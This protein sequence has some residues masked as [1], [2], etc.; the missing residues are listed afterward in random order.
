MKKILFTFVLAMVASLGYSQLSATRELDS[1]FTTY[2]KNGLFFANVLLKRDGKTLYQGTSGYQDLAAGIKNNSQTQMLI[3]SITKTYTAVV[4]LQLVEEGMLQLDDKLA[5]YYSEIPNAGRITLEALLRHRSGLFNYT[6]APS[7]ASEVTSS[8][9]KD[10][11]LERFKRLDTLFTPDT[12]FRYSNTNYLLLGYIIEKVTGDSYENQLRKRII[13]RLGLRATYYGRPVDRKNFARSYA[14]NGKEWIAAP[15][16]WNTSWIGGAGAITATAADLALFFESLFGG[17]LIS[18]ESLARM[19]RLK[20]DYGLGLMAVPYGEKRFYGHGG[21][22]EH[23]NSMAAYNPEDKTMIVNLVNAEKRFP[24]N[25]I[26][27]QLLNATYGY[28][29]EYPDLSDR[30]EVSVETTV[31]KGYEGTY[32]APGFPLEIQVFVKEGRLYGQATGQ[33]AFPLTAYSDT[34]FE[35]PQ[36][37]IGMNFFEKDGRRAFHFSQGP[38]KFDF[39]RKP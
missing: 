20:D 9:S 21:H 1:L 32:A 4:I 26:S 3:G 6:D 17:H 36:A 24:A 25:D 13:D 10:D 22:I 33:G 18:A 8:V 7:F 15:I 30:K 35:F 28:P 37:K 5:K 34:N 29:V 11:I 19:T 23:F 31:L 12:Q 16:D 2:D 27:I 14:D 39:V 38:A